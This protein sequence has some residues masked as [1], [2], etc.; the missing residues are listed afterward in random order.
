FI[1]STP[2]FLIRPQWRTHKRAPRNLLLDNRSVPP[3]DFTPTAVQIPALPA[4]TEGRLRRL[5]LVHLDPPARLAVVPQV[6]ILHPRT[7]RENLLRA[8][9]EGRIFLDAE[10]VAGQIEVQIR[11]VPYWRHIA[12]TVPS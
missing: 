8:L 7:A 12:G 5:L 10:V 2:T 9:V 1:C 3:A 11:H 6:A 4:R